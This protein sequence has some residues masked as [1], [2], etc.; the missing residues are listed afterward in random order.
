MC[1]KWK[2][3]QFNSINIFAASEQIWQKK[4]LAQKY[5]HFYTQVSHKPLCLSIKILVWIEMYVLYTEWSKSWSAYYNYFHSGIYSG[6]LFFKIWNYGDLL[7][8][9]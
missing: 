7:L 8:D 3:F 6:I 5:I 2:Q 9:I 4:K 1:M